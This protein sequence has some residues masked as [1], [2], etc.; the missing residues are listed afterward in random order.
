MP[1]PTREGY[2]FLGWGTNKNTSGLI[3]RT[4]YEMVVEKDTT[5]YAEWEKIQIPSKTYEVILDNG[6][7]CKTITVTNG[8]T[9]G[10]LPTPSRNGYTF[11][12]WYTQA[13][14]GSKITAST[15]VNL[16]VTRLY[17]PTGARMLSISTKKSILRSARNTRTIRSIPV[18]V[19]RFLQII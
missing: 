1:T 5:L 11:E 2:T 13:S 18:P 15:K 3:L 4:G 12:G 7:T 9:F 6:S 16:P 14:G 19:A 10:N 8:S 17:M